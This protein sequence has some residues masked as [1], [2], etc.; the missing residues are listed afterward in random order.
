M[1][2]LKRF[3]K[4]VH[5]NIIA[6]IIFPVPEFINKRKWAGLFKQNTIS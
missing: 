5:S 2:F 3:V 1:I 4:L 6:G